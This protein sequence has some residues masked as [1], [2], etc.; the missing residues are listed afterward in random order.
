MGRFLRIEKI[1]MAAQ[2]FLGPNWRH[3][4]HLRIEMWGTRFVGVLSAVAESNGVSAK[5]EG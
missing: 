4:P 3:I 2:V 1:E 5:M